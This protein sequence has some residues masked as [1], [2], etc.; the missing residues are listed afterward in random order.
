M[1]YPGSVGVLRGFVIAL[2]EEV[3]ETTITK[4]KG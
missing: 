1:A 2:P 3:R 4:P